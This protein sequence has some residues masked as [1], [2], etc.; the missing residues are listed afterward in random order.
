M[1]IMV[2]NG[3][4]NDSK[5]LGCYYILCALTLVN[6]DAAE[7]LPWLYESVNYNNNIN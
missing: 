3:I 6:S 2:N 5:A 1:E 7:S 4:N